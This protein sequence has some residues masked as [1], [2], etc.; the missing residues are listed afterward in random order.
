MAGL[1]GLPDSTQQRNKG[2]MG[3]TPAAAYVACLPI[4]G[5]GIS[6]NQVKQNIFF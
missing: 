1:E 5:K 3:V 2:F 6:S 4:T